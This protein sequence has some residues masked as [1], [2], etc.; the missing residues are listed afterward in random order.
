MNIYK[1]YILKLFFIY[2]MKIVLFIKN[3]YILENFIIFYN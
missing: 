1:Y 2:I 3:V